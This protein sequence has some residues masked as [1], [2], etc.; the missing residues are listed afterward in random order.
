MIALSFFNNQKT[1][2]DS[3]KAVR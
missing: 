1:D 3:F 2:M